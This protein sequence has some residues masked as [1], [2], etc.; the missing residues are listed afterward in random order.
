MIYRLK[1]LSLINTLF[2]RDDA[3]ALVLPTLSRQG[4]D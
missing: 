1:V 2:R 4:N 3:K